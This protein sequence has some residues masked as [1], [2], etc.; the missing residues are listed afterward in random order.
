M[1][2][3]EHIQ[4]TSENRLPPRAYY[5]PGG[6]G[7][8]LLLNGTWQ[9]AFFE[10]S[11]YA[12]EPEHFDT[13][14]VPSCWQM[15]GY[16][17]PNYTNVNYPFPVDPPYV[18]N[19]N[20]MG[21]YQR[22]FTLPEDE[23]QTYLVLEG[24]SACAVV[25]VNGQK[26]GFTQGSHLQ[27]EFDLTPYVH[28]G[29]NTLRI[30][31]YQWCV[32][33]YLEDQDFLRFSGLFR[34]V[35]LL[36]R[37][38]GHLHDFEL[39]TQGNTVTVSA[40]RPAQV[41]ILDGDQLLAQ[42]E[43]T[44]EIHLT[45]ENPTLWN[46]EAPYLYTLELSCAGE[47]IRQKFGFRDIAIS[48]KRELLLNGTPIKLR[49]V[50]HHD[51][52]PHG[53]WVITEAEVRKDLE[54]MK[55]L[56]INTIRTSHYPPIPQLPEIANEL[57]FYL[58]LESDMESHGF[59]NRMGG[60]CGYDA[61]NPVW[62]G[63]NPEWKNEHLE[64]MA[65][66]LERDKNQ[67]SVLIWS[68]G[69]ESGHGPNHGA[70]LDYL[71]RRDPSRLTHCEDESR[72]GHQTRADI[73]SC[74]YPS[75][76]NFVK[77]AENPEIPYPVF[78]CEYSHAMGNSPG[79]VWQ[80]WEEIY[81]RPNM[82]G[83]CI[84]EWCDHAVH[85]DG[86]LCYGGDFPGEL[87]NDGN[88]CCDGMVTAERKLKSGSLEIAAAYSPIRT[89]LRD[90]TVLV[91]NHLDFTDL[92]NYTLLCQVEADGEIL[93]ETRLLPHC[94]PGETLEI[95]L[96]TRLPVACRLGAHVRVT[97][98]KDG[99]RQ[100]SQLSLPL[101]TRLLP[102]ETRKSAPHFREDA[103]Y[104][105]A[106]GE[107][108]AYR[109]NKQTGCLDSLVLHGREWLCAPVEITAYRAPIDNER[110]VKARWYHENNWQGKIWTGSSATSGRC[111][112]TETP[113]WWKPP[114]PEFPGVPGSGTGWK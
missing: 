98:L 93:E 91:T 85:Q 55:A 16:G 95:P 9:F 80:Y 112:W 25:T 66:T 62:P 100:A 57:G 3:Y 104:I 108:F 7:Q 29:E 45:V 67:T 44:G 103:R 28:S 64:R 97:L 71:H 48:E 13:I 31:V 2:F 110:N 105:Y 30:Q 63:T 81:A 38:K 109:F 39:R 24:A 114:T 5:I 111:G 69:N 99:S 21:L 58:V 65:R 23:K 86:K 19:V 61:E 18:P 101:P 107:E 12:G 79:D 59:V 11:D 51:T 82:I 54:L 10:N 14:P 22:Q 89:A 17:H 113:L 50:N 33:S 96:E 92:E 87:T 27:S 35:Y 26:V 56:N 84:W 106:E 83:G 4:K 90:H 102:R 20:P 94:A 75:V 78:M 42:G 47:V 70:V 76:E 68:T 88:F 36:R 34:D 53:G 74:M 43:C 52:T 46:A 40:G 1:R 37:P 32:G 49:G 8:Q 60:C 15:Q 72:A 41:R 73:Y 6:A 77:M